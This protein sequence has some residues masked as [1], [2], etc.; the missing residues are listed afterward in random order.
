MDLEMN[1][2]LI[3]RLKRLEGETFYTKTGKPFEYR[4]AS[5]GVIHISG[6]KPYGISINNFEKALAIQPTKPS[7]ITNL[8]RGSAYVFGIITDAR[9]ARL[10]DAQ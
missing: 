3:S 8:V 5:E 2:D 9:F 10:T 6:R 7:Q 4:F 1:T